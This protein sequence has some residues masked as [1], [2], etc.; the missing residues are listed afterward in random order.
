MNLNKK[1][2]KDA[3]STITTDSV[4][5]GLLNPG[6]A[7]KFLQQTFDATPLMG[8]VRHVIKSEKS[9][10][11]DKI[12]I[13][14][15][16]LRAKAE[17]TDDGYRGKV[18][19]GVVNYQTKAVR[20]PWEITEETLRENIEGENFEKIVTDLMAKQVGCDTED[21]F[22]N[23]DESIDSSNEDYDF[24][25]LDDGVKKIITNNGHLIDV[26]GAADMDLE[27]FYKA[28]AAI[29]NKYNN[30]K[31][32]W[33]MSPTR[34]Q[35]WEL[36]L[37]NKVLDAGGAVPEA[38]YK[39][40]VAIPTM[41]VPSLDDGTILLADPQNFIVVNTYGVKIRKDASSKDAIMED[42]RFYVIHFDHDTVIEETDATAII[43]GLPSYKFSA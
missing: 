27:M 11:I 21:L 15:R 35:Q 22:V 34:A 32:R 8:A 31:L 36:F 4:T 14:R 24:L 17:N 6:Q 2:V 3:A 16:I 5:N 12:G 28:V 29:P 37:L 43:T 13:G 30:G 26:N 41:Q 39:S 18:K 1:I 10:E 9:G 25:K 20:L 42:K 33:M 19:F 23:G 7:K 38:L 40:P